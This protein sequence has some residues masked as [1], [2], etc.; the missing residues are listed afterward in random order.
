M[1]DEL[2]LAIVAALSAVT[3]AAIGGLISYYTNR[4]LQDREFERADRARLVQAKSA[5]SVEVGRFVT[6]RLLVKKMREEHLYP[7]VG[8]RLDDGL[9]I[10]ERQLV[11]S[12][13]DSR[14]IRAYQFAR[15]CIEDL[16]DEIPPSK[17]GHVVSRFVLLRLPLRDDCIA[18]GERALTPLAERLR[19]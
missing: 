12:H 10:T 19:E 4:S 17:E 18:G 9:T 14:T 8:D 15:D 5:A 13:L 16:R 6:A 1:S 2:K 3:G 11:I 7:V